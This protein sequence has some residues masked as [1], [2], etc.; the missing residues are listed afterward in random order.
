[1]ST[2]SQPAPKHTLNNKRLSECC[3]HSKS[4]AGLS[5]AWDIIDADVSRV[6]FEYYLMDT[7]INTDILLRHKDEFVRATVKGV[8]TNEYD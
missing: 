8:Q 4:Y 5:S 2:G 6:N 7:L 1:M 3:I